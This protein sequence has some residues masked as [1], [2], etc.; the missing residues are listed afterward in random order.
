MSYTKRKGILTHFCL[1]SVNYSQETQY[2][3]VYTNSH[4]ALQLVDSTKL[5][6]AGT[7]WYKTALKYMNCFAEISCHY[8][9]FEIPPF[10]GVVFASDLLHAGVANS[11]RCCTMRG[12]CQFQGNPSLGFK[13]V[14]TVVSKLHHPMEVDHQENICLM[15]R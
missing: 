15:V 10:G 5:S 7:G 2:L 14:D 13:L 8:K 1:F 9:R 4:M 6:K 11:G 12:F 3:D